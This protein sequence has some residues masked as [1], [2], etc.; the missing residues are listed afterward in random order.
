MT[1]IELKNQITDLE[2]VLNARRQEL[3]IV[4]RIEELD[5]QAAELN[6]QRQQAADDLKRFQ[7]QAVLDA[8]KPTDPVQEPEPEPVAAPVKP[9]LHP[10]QEKLVGNIARRLRSESDKTDEQWEKFRM[11]PIPGRLRP[12]SDKTDELIDRV[13]LEGL[14]ALRS[15]CDRLGV[16][17]SPQ[18]RRQIKNALRKRG[19]K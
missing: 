8:L 3:A 6:R 18:Y 4:E 13:R 12:E 7:A 5:A 9:S 19:A 10:D 1:S 15:L 16:T 14:P 17:Y 11:Q 2:R